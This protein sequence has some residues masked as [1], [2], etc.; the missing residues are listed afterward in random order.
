MEES[1]WGGVLQSVKELSKLAEEG[2]SLLRSEIQVA[3]FHH[4]YQL[5]HLR[6]GAGLSQEP[7]IIVLALNQHLFA[8]QDA[9]LAGKLRR[10]LFLSVLNEDV[11]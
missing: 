11:M 10:N 6:L 5:S 4:L 2:L 3:C 7:E 9:V 8:F 1:I